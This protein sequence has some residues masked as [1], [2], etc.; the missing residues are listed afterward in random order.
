MVRMDWFISNLL[1]G[2]K[3]C[4][5]EADEEAALNALER[6][7]PASIEV[8]GVGTY[9]QPSCPRCASLDV[10]FEALNRPIAYG[11]AWLGIPIPLRRKRWKCNAGGQM[12]KIELDSFKPPEHL[13]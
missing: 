6:P 7:T 13:D 9:D 2:I 8:E 5:R 10:T 3:L 4:V 11:T 1:G 12:W